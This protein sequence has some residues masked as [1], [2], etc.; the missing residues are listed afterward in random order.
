MKSL[1]LDMNRTQFM[2]T[3]QEFRYLF[4]QFCTKPKE[5]EF[6]IRLDLENPNFQSMGVI[7]EE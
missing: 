5:N 6:H 4:D 3:Y 1:Q 2:L 7:I